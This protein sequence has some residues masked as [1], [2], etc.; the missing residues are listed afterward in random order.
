M[1]FSSRN[2]IFFFLFIGLNENRLTNQ[3]FICWEI[4][5]A[6]I[7]VDILCGKNDI[8]FKFNAELNLAANFF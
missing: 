6:T 4:I 2:N 1:K 3:N 8:K 5:C 7:N